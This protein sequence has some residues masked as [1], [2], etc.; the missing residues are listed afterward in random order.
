MHFR[1]NGAL[2]KRMFQI[3]SL[4]IVEIQKKRMNKRKT[5]IVTSY[6][7]SFDPNASNKFEKALRGRPTPWDVD[8]VKGCNEM[9]IVAKPGIVAHRA[10]AALLRDRGYTPSIAS[11]PSF[12]S[13]GS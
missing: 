10:A 1:N 2:I 3:P 6:K 12:A 8:I 13:N 11:S 9:N 7:P 5:S 4:P